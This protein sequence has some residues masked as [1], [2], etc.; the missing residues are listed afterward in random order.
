MYYSEKK[1]AWV[2]N[3][4]FVLT[5]EFCQ[6]V[7]RY[8]AIGFL[9]LIDKFNEVYIFDD[10]M[11]LD[12]VLRSSVV[13]PS[14]SWNYAELREFVQVSCALGEF[15]YQCEFIECNIPSGHLDNLRFHNL[16]YGFVL[17]SGP[18]EDRLSSYFPFST[19]GDLRKY[20]DGDEDL[21]EISLEHWEQRISDISFADMM[22]PSTNSTR[23][24]L[25]A[26]SDLE[27]A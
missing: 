22:F 17:P 18:S 8:L 11:N 4:G 24:D 21:K 14:Q 9:L 27:P 13:K 15:E 3:S 26:S 1:E 19:V 5:P 10:T 16:W 12:D 23:A 6:D 20:V 7:S 25:V 2:I